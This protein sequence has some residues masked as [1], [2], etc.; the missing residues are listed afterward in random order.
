MGDFGALSTEFDMPDADDALG[1]RLGNSYWTRY[2]FTGL[3]PLSALDTASPSSSMAENIDDAAASKTSA[4]D[5]HDGRIDTADVQD[6]RT[7]NDHAA[8]RAAE[9]NGLNL[10]VRGSLAFRPRHPSTAMELDHHDDESLRKERSG[11]ESDLEL[12]LSGDAP[13][14]IERQLRSRT[15]TRQATSGRRRWLHRYGVRRAPLGI[16]PQRSF[17]RPGADKGLLSRT[18][19]SGSHPGN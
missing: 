18:A 14:N 2:G 10:V 13:E 6:S 12:F 1:Q 9:S 11:F 16:T 7:G 4:A 15:A 19:G 8:Q 5:E 17:A 3:P